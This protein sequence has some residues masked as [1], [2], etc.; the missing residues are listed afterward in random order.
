MFNS[1]TIYRKN[2]EILTTIIIKNGTNE[3]EIV[4]VKEEYWQEL[5]DAVEEAKQKSNDLRRYEHYRQHTK[6][7]KQKSI[8]YKGEMLISNPIKA[9]WREYF[10]KFLAIDEPNVES[11]IEEKIIKQMKQ[12]D[13]I[14]IEDVLEPLKRP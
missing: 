3:D 11:E 14:K 13:N 1:K 2:K 7:Y 8:R 6:R 4:K 5:S 12:E 9:R 10:I